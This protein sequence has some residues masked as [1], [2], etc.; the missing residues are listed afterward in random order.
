MCI[1]DRNKEKKEYIIWEIN[2]APGL[3]PNTMRIYANEL[4]EYI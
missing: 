1:R 2:T 4:R 3:N